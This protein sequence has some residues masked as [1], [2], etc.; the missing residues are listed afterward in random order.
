MKKLVLFFYLA[1]CTLA[2]FAST[3]NITKASDCFDI[4]I[5]VFTPQVRIAASYT[6]KCG[7]TWNIVAYGA[8]YDEAM[9]G[10][11]N[12]AKLSDAACGTNISEII[13]PN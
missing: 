11:Q 8:S 13:V 10:L 3:P 7:V 2:G 12:M 6:S 5:S 9:Q 1:F 4:S